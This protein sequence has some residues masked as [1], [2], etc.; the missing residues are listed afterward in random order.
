M[1][2]APSSSPF[3]WTSLP[4]ETILDIVTQTP[5]VPETFLK[6]RLVDRRLNAV[7]ENYERAICKA[8]AAEQFP[9]VASDFP[10][11]AL[12]CR[13]QLHSAVSRGGPEDLSGWPEYSTADDVEY[14]SAYYSGVGGETTRPSFAWLAEVYQRYD[15]IERLERL[16]AC[17]GI[18]RLPLLTAAL[19]LLYR[20]TD[21]GNGNH[22]AKVDFLWRLPVSGL[23]TLCWCLYES[24]NLARECGHGVIN[25]RSNA[26]AHHT[27]EAHSDLLLAFE[28]ML[29]NQG[30]EFLLDLLGRDAQPAAAHPRQQTLAGQLRRALAHKLAI[31]P[32]FVFL[33]VCSLLNHPK[34]AELAAADAVKLVAGQEIEEDET[35]RFVGG[36][37][38]Q[39]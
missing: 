23:V 5:F 30:P 38:L 16:A 34:L 36:Y 22:D 28:E 32:S 8:I 9:H 2:T 20:L 26:Y 19:K 27:S 15:T 33:N 39:D 24:I 29:L 31:E 17:C 13:R 10:G 3:P 1:A 37:R 12:L 21:D 25:A 4:V 35:D 11:I 18:Q 6:L 7:L 14:A